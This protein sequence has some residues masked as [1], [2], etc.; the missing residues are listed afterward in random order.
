[1]GA[2]F[3]LEQVAYALDGAPNYTKVDVEGDLDRREEFVRLCLR[4]LSL[5]PEG[6]TPA[7]A[8]DRLT[9]LDSGERRKLALAARQAEQRA[10][11]IRK[12]MAEKAAQ[13]A[14]AKYGRE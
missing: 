14:A 5:H 4:E 10:Q 1:M 9:A 7:Q 8:E 2:S 13:E 6:E 11:E 12:K 3:G